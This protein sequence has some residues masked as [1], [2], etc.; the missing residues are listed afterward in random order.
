MATQVTMIIYPPFIQQNSTVENA[1]SSALDKKVGHYNGYMIIITP[2]SFRG[3]YW[4][5]YTERRTLANV[6]N[7]GFANFSSGFVKG[8]KQVRR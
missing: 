1:E 8:C 3:G 4:G 2:D 5:Y 7:F 6:A